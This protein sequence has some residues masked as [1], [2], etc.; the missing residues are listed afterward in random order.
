MITQGGN[1]KR[2]VG[3]PNL[4]VMYITPIKTTIDSKKMQINESRRDGRGAVTPDSDTRR[5]RVAIYSFSTTQA[6][7]QVSNHISLTLENT[8]M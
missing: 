4:P 6:R 2:E 1:I 8:K 3:T 5:D 7:G